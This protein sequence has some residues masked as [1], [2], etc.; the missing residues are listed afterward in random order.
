LDYAKE[1]FQ[2]AK[3]LSASGL[4]N[5]LSAKRSAVCLESIK[6]VDNRKFD[7]AEKDTQHCSAKKNFT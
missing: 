1:N 3:I 7:Q 5:P 2:S 4:F 6:G